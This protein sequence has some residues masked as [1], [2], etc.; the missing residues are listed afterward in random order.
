VLPIKRA[1][2][3]AQ[4]LDAGDIATLTVELMDL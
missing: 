4:A 1:V 2:G 3:K